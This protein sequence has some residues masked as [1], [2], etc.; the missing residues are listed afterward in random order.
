VGGEWSKGGNHQSA[1]I[2]VEKKERAVNV[3]AG[4]AGGPQGAAHQTRPKT[5]SEETEGM[6]CIGG[7]VLMRL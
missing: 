3:Q 1:L 5:L 4:A 2:F 7:A 6:V